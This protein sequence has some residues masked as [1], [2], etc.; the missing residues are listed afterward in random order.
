MDIIS[1]IPPAGAEGIEL[2]HTG[3][4][5]ELYSELSNMLTMT[6]KHYD[7]CDRTNQI[8]E[9]AQAWTSQYDDLTDAYLQYM[10]E[11]PSDV[12]DDEA[13]Q[14]TIETMIPANPSLD[15]SIRIFQHMSAY[16]NVSLMHEGCIGASPIKP[17]VA[18]TIC[19]LEVYCQTHCV[20]PHFSIHAE[21]KKLCHLHGI[22]YHQYL[23]D[24]L[25]VAFDVYIKVQCHVDTCVDSALGRDSPNWHMLNACPACHYEVEDELTMPFFFQLS[26][27]GNNSAKL[28]NP[29]LHHGNEHPD[30]Q[31]QCCYFWMSEEYVDRFKHEQ[32]SLPTEVPDLGQ[33]TETNDTWVDEPDSDDSSSSEPVSVCLDQWRNAA[34]EVWKRMFAVF[35]KSGI[36]VSICC[37]RILLTICDM[38]RSGE[39]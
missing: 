4:E 27:D 33:A 18:I 13:D 35:R 16:L 12:S 22:C 17:M 39:L 36:F 14:F 15:H 31:D 26:M 1:A 3:G 7:H 37:H 34:P 2:S 6:G 19:T 28:V 23:A 24:Q 9:M 29:I 21:A 20:C 38:M 8:V 25:Q 32:A 30:P 11:Q 10:E 5:Y